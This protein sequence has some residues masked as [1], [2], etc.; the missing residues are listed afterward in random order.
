MIEWRVENGG[1]KKVE[2][3]ITNGKQTETYRVYLTWIDNK[4][5]K[6]TKY[7]ELKRNDKK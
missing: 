7:E 4:G 2:A 1:N 3:T 5:W 6:V